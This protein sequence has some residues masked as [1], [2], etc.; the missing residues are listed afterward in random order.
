MTF[1]PLHVVSQAGNIPLME[2]LISRG[3]RME[4]K[5]KLEATPLHQAAICKQMQASIF[6]LDHG[7]NVN[8]SDKVGQTPLMMAVQVNS[9]PL[10]DLFLLRG[11]DTSLQ[12]NHRSTGP[13]PPFIWHHSMTGWTLPDEFWRQM[14]M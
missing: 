9:A 11:A 10:V 14:Q 7:A 4:V 1:T 13:G 8:A 3:A 2:I 12:T 6:P 5:T